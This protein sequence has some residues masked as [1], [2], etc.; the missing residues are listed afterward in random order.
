MLADYVREFRNLRVDLAHGP[1][2]V[3]KPCMLLVAI[4]LIGA[5]GEN[6]ILYE[7]TRD[8]FRAYACAVRPEQDMKPYLPFYHLQSAHFWTLMVPKGATP[9]TKA[10]HGQLVGVSARLDPELYDL[11]REGRD[12]RDELRYVLIDRW[13]PEKRTEVEAVIAQAGLSGEL[14]AVGR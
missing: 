12:A 9:P 10:K 14:S 1:E 7:D 3:H 5:F 6:R 13:F 8:R 4:D 2:R 11:L